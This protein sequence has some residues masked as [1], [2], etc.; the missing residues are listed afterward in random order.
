VQVSH[1]SLLGPLVLRFLQSVAGNTDGQG[2]GRLGDQTAQPN[3]GDMN[4]SADHMRSDLLNVGGL[5]NLSSQTNVSAGAM[6]PDQS[7][8]SSGTVVNADQDQQ[9]HPLLPPHG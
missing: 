3:H 5:A 1:D 8:Q 6:K 9:H 4:L 7:Q 2:S